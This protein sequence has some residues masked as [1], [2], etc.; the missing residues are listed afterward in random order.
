MCNRTKLAQRGFSTQKCSEAAR[1]LHQRRVQHG[2]QLA[3][4]QRVRRGRA[5]LQERTERL[6]QARRHLRAARRFLSSGKAC[7]TKKRCGHS[8]ARYCLY[9]WQAW[10]CCCLIV[11]VLGE[12]RALTF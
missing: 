6:Q 4:R 1:Q 3:P 10:R 11:A 2:S 5:Q 8:T 7:V 12:H 9:G